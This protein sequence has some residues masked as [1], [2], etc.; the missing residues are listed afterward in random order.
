MW[1]ESLYEITIQILKNLT[2]SYLTME[3]LFSNNEYPAMIILL[4]THV[5]TKMHRKVYLTLVFEMTTLSY[6]Y[7]DFFL[8]E[9]AEWSLLAKNSRNSEQWKSGLKVCYCFMGLLEENF[10]FIILDIN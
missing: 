8:K 6:T 3:Q 1:S 7:Y 5:H 2:P 4:H 9:M 10:S